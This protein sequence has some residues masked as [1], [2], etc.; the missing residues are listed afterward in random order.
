MLQILKITKTSEFKQIGKN[1][2][3]FYSQ[4]LILLRAKTPKEYSF[5]KNEGKNSEE[6]CR[7]GFTASK[8]VGNAV[9]RNRAKRRLR[10]AAKQMLPEYGK[11]G[12]DYVIIAKTQIKDVDF[13][14][15]LKDLKFCVKR[16]GSG[17]SKK[18]V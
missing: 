5:D 14:K 2:D 7:I 15:I 16:I 17:V 8:K 13:D 3:K 1:C 11:A 4:S 9:V 18:Q 10:E 6:F 12:F